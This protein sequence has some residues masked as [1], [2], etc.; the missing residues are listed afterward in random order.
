MHLADCRNYA[1]SIGFAKLDQV[2]GSNS[3]S[4]SSSSSSSSSRSSKWCI[5]IHDAG[6]SGRVPELSCSSCIVGRMCFVVSVILGTKSAAL[7]ALSLS[8]FI[9]YLQSVRFPLTT[10][11]VCELISLAAALKSSRAQL[12][13]VQELLGREGIFRT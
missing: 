2:R 3:Q 11:M 9:L 7:V 12:E 6:S 1:A 13:V 10:W 8:L 4:S 5:T